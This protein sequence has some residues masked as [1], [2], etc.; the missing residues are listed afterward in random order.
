MGGTGATGRLVFDELKQSSEVQKILFL[1]RRDVDSEQNP[2]V[3]GSNTSSLW[4]KNTG[5]V[6]IFWLKN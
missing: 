1:T 5:I 2:K 4:E 3:S 6:Y